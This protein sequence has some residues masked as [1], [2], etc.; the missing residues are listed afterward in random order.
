M[1]EGP[2]LTIHLFDK[3][4]I[5]SKI[6]KEFENDMKR[7]PYNE[8]KLRELYTFVKKITPEFYVDGSMHEA[9]RFI[10][11]SARDCESRLPNGFIIKSNPNFDIDEPKI[12]G[13]P[14]EDI[15]DYIVYEIRK[16]LLSNHTSSIY[17]PD[18]NEL[19]FTNDCVVSSKKGKEIC[20]FLNIASY[21]LQIHPG[22]SKKARLFDGKHYHFCNIV[23]LNNKYYLID[24]T[25]RQFFALKKNNLDRIGVVGLGGCNVGTFMLMDTLR[26]QVAKRILKEGW[27]E[28]DDAIFKAYLDGFAISFRNGLFY[29]ET[30]DFSYTTNY[31]AEDYI[32]F[33]RN[34]DNQINHESRLVLGYQKRPLNQ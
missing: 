34:E 17:K 2:E 20:D 13:S 27:I 19:P 3:Q 12:I 24:C 26:E 32:R 15:L 11:L 29:E 5:Y 25:Y 16:F 7:M 8:K 6:I 1:L 31:N 22:F 28:L 4:R 9:Y 10:T 23:R 30:K 18:I 14:I 21:V 33:L